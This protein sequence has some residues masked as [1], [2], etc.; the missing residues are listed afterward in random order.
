MR[1]VFIFMNMMV[2]IQSDPYSLEKNKGR[3]MKI[4]NYE[5]LFRDKH[6]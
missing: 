4:G 5:R 1:I 3:V 2:L 6:A